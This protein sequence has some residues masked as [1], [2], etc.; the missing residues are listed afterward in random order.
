MSAKAPIAWQKPLTLFLGF[1]LHQTAQM[2]DLGFVP[3]C[4]IASSIIMDGSIPSLA[5]VRFPLAKAPQRSQ[6][7]EQIEYKNTMARTGSQVR[8]DPP[9][10]HPS[11]DNP[12]GTTV[13][14][15]LF[16]RS[17][18][19]SPAYSEETRAIPSKHEIY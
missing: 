5:F 4:Q 16:S 13:H 18:Q 15:A 2:Q 1:P 10:Y 17:S 6:I 8:I 12:S 9:R 7:Q 3:G 19:I 14:R 11:I